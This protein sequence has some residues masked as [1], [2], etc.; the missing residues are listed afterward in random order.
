VWADNETD[1]DLLG[2]D[3]IVDALVVAL[4][5]PRLL[6][7][8]VGVLGDWGSGK[9]SLMKIVRQE[10]EAEDDTDESKPRDESK[11]RY[12]CVEFSPWHY[13]DYDDVK[14]ALMSAVLDRLEAEI[15]PE[16]RE[17][18]SKLRQFTE[19]LRR[20]SRWVGRAASKALGPGAVF[21][22]QALDS[23]SA[24]DPATRGLV[25]GTAAAV[26][27]EGER[28][29]AEPPPTPGR[30]PAEAAGDPVAEV[31]SFRAQFGKLVA[32]L[33]EVA[34]IVV[35]IDDLDRCLPET[36]VDT[37]EA[38]RLFLNTDKTAYV[39][40]ANQ[41]VVETA[42]DSRYP[43]LRREGGTGIGA[44]YLEKMLQLKVVIPA[45]SV[46][47]AET[48]MNLLLAELRLDDAAFEQVRTEVRKWRAENNLM[49]AF[50]LGVAGD[51][52]GDDV[53][54]ELVRDL[55]WAATVGPAL[56]AG[57]RGNP[58]QLKRFLNNLLLKVR[59]AARRGVEL[60]PKVL[61][62]LLVLE[63]QHVG[64]FQRLFDWQLTAAGPIPELAAA[65]AA[66]Q[67]GS[68]IEV[69]EAQGGQADGGQA[70]AEPAGREAAPARGRRPTGTGKAEATAGSRTKRR[71]TGP[72]LHDEVA[73]WAAK[74]HVRAWLA[75]PPGLG[76]VDLRPYFT[77]SR[78]KL[79]LGVVIS[80][81]PP[82]LQ[83]LL[84]QAE[85]EVDRVRRAALERVKELD[86]AERELV[87]SGLLERLTRN[88]AGP[89]FAA[90]AELA[91]RVPETVAAVCEAMMKIPPAAVP[92]QRA[93]T[94]VRRLPTGHPAVEGLL[95]RWQN[96]G[97]AALEQVTAT[98]R[99]ARRQAAARSTRPG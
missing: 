88:P 10:L 38:I 85:S 22:V 50:N 45:L 21:A 19:G 93:P 72:A 92:A 1:V 73:A 82:H 41:Q 20:R 26:G 60:D 69:S 12:V 71:A 53:P 48:Y 61:A 96:S 97:V 68:P 39:V 43:E 57:G 78:D 64:D 70:D 91:E 54:A 52:L 36:V 34:A 90:A 14:V 35:F 65:E 58:R 86:E 51:I 44:D 11:L 9:S 2:F 80:R 27:A 6:P 4:T 83:E 75:L 33:D 67:P 25:Q 81:L 15:K 76:E 63:D 99:Q 18:V 66:L 79:S 13:E 56:G 31:G 95:D 46:P 98:A 32:G 24:L 5:E 84:V 89:A 74:P 94:V 62:K 29:F 37:F 16:E 59:S 3:F 8:T 30:P 77:Y 28:L 49:V 47:E 55:E 40:A 87:V 23:D 7:L 42:I 17:Q